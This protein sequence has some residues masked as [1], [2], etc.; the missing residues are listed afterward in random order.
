MFSTAADLN[1]EWDSL[2]DSPVTWTDCPELLHAVT[3]GDALALIGAFPDPILAFL[4]DRTQRGDELAGRTICQAFLGKL[5]TMAAKARARGIPDAL[6]DCLASMWLTITDYPLDRRP[7]KIAANLVMDV[8]QHTL[9]HWMTPTDPHEVPVPPSVALDTVPPQPPTEDL[10][11]PDI[12]ALARQHHWI[13][14]AQANL[15]TEVYVDGMSGAQ[16]A[17]RH[18]CR[19]ATVR[20]QCRHGVAKLRARADEILTT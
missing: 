18:S 14:P 20:S 10:T 8:H 5:I 2:Q 4:I 16:A 13:S 12:I 6:D 1:I 3:A 19:P 17:A 9:A 15:L 11:A 7:T